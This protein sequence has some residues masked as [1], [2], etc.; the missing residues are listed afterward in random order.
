MLASTNHTKV[1]AAH[2]RCPC[3]PTRARQS[4]SAPQPFFHLVLG[5]VPIFRNRE[6]LSLI[7]FRDLSPARASHSHIWRCTPVIDN[8]GVI[9]MLR[10]CDAYIR[11]CLLGD[12]RALANRVYVPVKTIVLEVHACSAVVSRFVFWRWTRFAREGE[13]LELWLVW[14]FFFE[15]IFMFVVTLPLLTTGLV[16]SLRNMK[17]RWKR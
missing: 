15:G 13:R 8:N 16:S 14:L 7:E 5:P 9:M 12:I 1:E 4:A 2:A 6:A 11:W 10:C 3:L 17:P